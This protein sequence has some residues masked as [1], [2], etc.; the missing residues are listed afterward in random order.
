[1]SLD[2]TMTSGGVQEQGGGSVKTGGELE[3]PFEG[4]PKPGLT[5]GNA[6]NDRNTAPFDKPRASGGIPVKFYETIAAS[7]ATLEST[8]ENAGL[9]R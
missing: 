7:P 1:M 5:G 8:L 6:V 3:S 4:A 2:S 9:V